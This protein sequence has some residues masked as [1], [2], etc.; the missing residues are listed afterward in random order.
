MAYL[1]V[2]GASEHNRQDVSASGSSRE[3]CAA[4]QLFPERIWC[5]LPATNLPKPMKGWGRVEGG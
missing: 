4:R 1:K 3:G 5:I 2:C